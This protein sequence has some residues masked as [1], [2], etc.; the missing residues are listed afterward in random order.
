[1]RGSRVRFDQFRVNVERRVSLAQ[2]PEMLLAGAELIGPEAPSQLTKIQTPSTPEDRVL[3]LCLDFNNAIG[4]S[5]RRTAQELDRRPRA[6]R[7]T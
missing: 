3:N 6:V 1:L 7:Y 4:H 5:E 2:S